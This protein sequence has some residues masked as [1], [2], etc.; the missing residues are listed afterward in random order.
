LEERT[1]EIIERFELV[2]GIGKAL[3]VGGAAPPIRRMVRVGATVLQK[4]SGTL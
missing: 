1:L 3:E 4:I 2:H